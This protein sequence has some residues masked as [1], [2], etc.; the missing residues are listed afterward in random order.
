MHASPASSA[1][2]EECLID[3]FRTI[4]A[5]PAF[6][7]EAA[8]ADRENRQ[9]RENIRQLTETGFAKAFLPRELG[10][11]DLSALAFCRINE[12][13]AA[14]DGS[15][16]TIWNMTAG[17]YGL[18]SLMPPFP[19]LSAVLADCRDTGALICGGISAPSG[20]L[21]ASK[22]GFVY[23]EDGD[24]FTVT[25]RGGFAT[26]SETAKYFTVIGALAPAGVTRLATIESVVFG[27]AELSDPGVTV[28]GN[29]DAMGQRATGSHDIA[30]SG[31][32]VAKA[33]CLILPADAMKNIGALIPPHL[34]P[35]RL[36]AFAGIM[37]C[38]VGAARRCQ[39]LL[40][41]HLS[42][43][44]GHVSVPEG[45][46]A[47]PPQSHAET[48]WAR[49][50]MGQLDLA[51]STARLVAHAFARDLDAHGDKGLETQVALIRAIAQCKAMMETFTTGVTA[52][53]G[54]HGYV[55]GSPLNLALRDLIGFNA[56]VWRIDDLI[57]SLG[58]AAFGAPV[59]LSGLGGT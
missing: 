1:T 11:D 33:D 54:A 31:W 58:K 17:N 42:K 16:A 48:N 39:E 13:V 7:A 57:E 20:E 56:M 28:C 49:F 4:C 51:L 8:L 25:G 19:R 47:P 38:H 34:A 50:R 12:E 26:G 53:S 15:L 27:L 55:A 10:G 18:L 6:R 52:L 2:A 41:V 23:H 21:D 43:R 46:A 29:W 9:S 44:R 59:T 35:R 24:G 32:R 22:G 37:G 45:A 3:R 5:E 40:A 30:L 36:K 14:A